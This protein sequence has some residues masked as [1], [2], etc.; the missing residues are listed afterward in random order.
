MVSLYFAD[1]LTG[2][3]PF[4]ED[5][6]YDESWVELSIDECSDYEMFTSRTEIFSF[7][8]SKHCEGWQFR[9]MDYIAYQLLY[10][11]KVIITGSW[12]SKG[13]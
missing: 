1:T 2:K 9:A 7:K 10:Q 12:S 11:R 13:L 4:S 5:G 6:L 3:N 8:L